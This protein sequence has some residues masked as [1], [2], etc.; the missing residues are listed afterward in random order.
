MWA[1]LGTLK[2]RQA[3]QLIT[4]N[5]MK[6]NLRRASKESI[7][8]IKLRENKT[9]NESFAGHGSDSSW[10]SKI[11]YHSTLFRCFCFKLFSDATK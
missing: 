8:V 1:D 2:M 10:K 9:E 4:L 7:T 5:F 6:E 11:F 3:E